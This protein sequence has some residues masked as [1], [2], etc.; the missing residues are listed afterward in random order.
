MTTKKEILVFCENCRYY[1]DDM[2]KCGFKKGEKVTPVEIT[3]VYASP[4]ED[5]KHNNC[6]YYKE[7]REQSRL[8]CAAL[9]V[10]GVSLLCSLL[11]SVVFAS[12]TWLL[13]SLIWIT[14]IFLCVWINERNAA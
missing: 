9:R 1:A 14:L 5:N 8:E 12:D 7:P 6:R 4:K 11:F 2:K 10:M 13:I 3:D